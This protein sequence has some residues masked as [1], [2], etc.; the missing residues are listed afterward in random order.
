[1][2]R[3]CGLGFDTFLLDD[4]VEKV[5]VADCAFSVGRNI[6]WLLDGAAEP[7]TWPFRGVVVDRN[8]GK[9]LKINWSLGGLKGKLP[10]ALGRLKWIEAINFTGNEISEELP[11]DLAKLHR[12]LGENMKWGPAVTYLGMERQFYK[13]KD[14]TEVI[15]PDR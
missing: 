4:N 8:G 13:R 10:I 5:A 11:E 15:I 2:A 7:G 9:V 14:V 3:K 1:M 12:K 6:K